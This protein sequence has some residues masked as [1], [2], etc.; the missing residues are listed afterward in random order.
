[1]SACNF[2]H[3]LQNSVLQLL[4]GVVLFLLLLFQHLM[5]LK[6][7]LTGLTGHGCMVDKLT[8]FAVVL[9]GCEVS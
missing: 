7:F 5:A 2:L 1:M 8:F 6:T 4:N 3:T 9:D